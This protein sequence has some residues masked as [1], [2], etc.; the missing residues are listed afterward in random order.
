MDERND[1]LLF[2]VVDLLLAGFGGGSGMATT[3]DDVSVA[4]MVVVFLCYI[5]LLFICEIYFV[6]KKVTDFVT[7]VVVL[8]SICG[9]GGG[10]MV[11]VYQWWWWWWISGGC[12]RDGMGERMMKF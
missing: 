12:K 2:I 6:N 10:S 11:V 7:V 5:F 4:R 9:G 8:L 3:M 1:I